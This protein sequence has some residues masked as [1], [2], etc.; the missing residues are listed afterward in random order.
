[1]GIKQRPNDVLVSLNEMI[2]LRAAIDRAIDDYKDSC[3]IKNTE[4]G[5]V[6]KPKD[7][8]DLDVVG[9]E[10]CNYVLGVMKQ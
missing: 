7:K 2:Y 3:S 6:I 9:H 8:K 5:L 1:M 10:F 4:E